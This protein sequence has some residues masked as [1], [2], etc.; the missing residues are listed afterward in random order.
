MAESVENLA[1]FELDTNHCSLLI[2]QASHL[3][4]DGYWV[5]KAI[6]PLHSSMPVIPN[7]PLIPPSCGLSGSQKLK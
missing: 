6:F 4:T 1:K 5:G 3:I 7:G 2:H